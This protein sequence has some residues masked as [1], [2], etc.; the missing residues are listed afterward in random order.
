MLTESTYCNKCNKCNKKKP[1]TLFET[2]NRAFSLYPYS[3][4]AFFSYFI[5]MMLQLLHLLQYIE[6]PQ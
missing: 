2:K 6:K 3:L 5:K 1:K 4:T